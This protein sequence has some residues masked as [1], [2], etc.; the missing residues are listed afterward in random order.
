[1]TAS[2]RSLGY[3]RINSTDLDAWK[4]FGENL[5]G[6]MVV[7]ATGERVRFRI[8]EYEYRIEVL[9]ADNDNVTTIGWEVATEA[10]LEE[11]V[12]RLEEA[13]YKVEQL[14]KDVA[15]ERNVTRL[16]TFRDPDDVL[17]LELYVGLKT[18]NERFY[19]TKGATF[20]A[21]RALGLGH[22]FQVV[23]D[24][25]KYDELYRTILGFRLSDYI[26]VPPNLEATFLHCNP[27]HHSF[28]YVANPKRPLGPGHFMVE[29]DDLDSVGR[30]WQ[31]MLDEKAPVIQTLGRHT[32]DKMISA[33]VKTPSNVGVEYGFGG[34]L[35]DDATWTPTRYDW[36]HYWGHEKQ[37]L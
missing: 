27:R 23:G 30:A 3:L 26:E 6:L 7:E 8:D 1:M 13:G 2:V 31:Q 28:A 24:A 33:Y 34:L 35:V 37:A 14:G 21:G 18:A 12:S 32:N 5:L 19:S 4:E 29:V 16:A 9:A 22:V 17:S 11:L 36:A 15:K 10:D 25:E 20:V